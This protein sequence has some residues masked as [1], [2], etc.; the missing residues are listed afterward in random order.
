MEQSPSEIYHC[1]SGEVRKV[2][3][4]P[5]VSV[6]FE[7]MTVDFS[8]EEWQHLDSAQRFLYQDMMLK[9]TATSSLSLGMHSY[10]VNL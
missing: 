1:R 6:S 7:D 5:K 8:R 3:K 2:H 4:V 10:P 9:T